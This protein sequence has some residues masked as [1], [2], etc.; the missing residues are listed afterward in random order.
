MTYVKHIE[1]VVKQIFSFKK[2]TWLSLL[3]YIKRQTRR[4]MSVC[5]KLGEQGGGGSIVV[6]EGVIKGGFGIEPAQR[7]LTSLLS[8]FLIRYIY[9]EVPL[10]PAA[11]RSS[12]SWPRAVS[13][14]S[15]LMRFISV[16]F[17][18]DRHLSDARGESQPSYGCTCQPQRESGKTPPRRSYRPS[19]Q[20]RSCQR[21]SLALRWPGPRFG[22]VS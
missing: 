13:I 21:L 3:D 12:K 5:V 6:S 1:E 9:R 10:F 4:L 15:S 16:F 20:P 18:A 11:L 14:I 2:Q 17:R 19:A 8:F 22:H 7:A